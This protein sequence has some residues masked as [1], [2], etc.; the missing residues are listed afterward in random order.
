MVPKDVK[1]DAP[2]YYQITVV[3][4]I[5]PELIEKFGTINLRVDKDQA[6]KISH[7]NVLVKDQAQLAGILT[8][9]Y[10]NHH[11]ILSVECVNC[12]VEDTV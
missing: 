8:S 10:N 3:G 1:F 2:A 7:L 4:R 5:S 6:K 11:V 9:L 12:E